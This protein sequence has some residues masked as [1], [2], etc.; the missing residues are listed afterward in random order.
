MLHS[1][2]RSALSLMHACWGNDLSKH[3]L[4]N[5]MTDSKEQIEEYLK[6]EIT[7]SG[8]PFEIFSS[9]TLS[10][11]GWNCEIHTIYYSEQ[12]KSF[13]EIDIRAHKLDKHFE[14]VSDV[15]VIE[16]KKQEKKPWVFFEQD[17]PNTDITTLNAVPSSLYMKLKP[18]FKKH[19]YF[20]RKPCSF[21]F[22]SFVSHGKPDVIL[23]AI[24]QVLNALDYCLEKEN[25]MQPHL[26]SRKTIS[27]PVILLDGKLF[28]ARVES[29]G[30]IKL[31]E[32]KHLQLMVRR[33]L[34][35]PMQVQ[36]SG[37]DALLSPIKL[38]IIDIVRKDGL[39]EFLEYF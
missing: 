17:R 36:I 22:P 34:P 23:D 21:H 7:K 9:I 1:L 16:C 32:S 5:F 38:Y 4:L 27:Y 13:S 8:F 2:N 19:Y 11:F 14:G 6:R 12:T 39:E 28:S 37:T 33:G 15:L 31:S 10:K 25:Q 26:E 20:N 18:R 35:S 3:E 24:N 29:D 30:D